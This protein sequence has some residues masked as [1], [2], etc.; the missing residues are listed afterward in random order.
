LARRRKGISQG[1]AA[2][3]LGIKQCTYASYEKDEDRQFRHCPPPDI[4]E[5]ESIDPHEHVVVLRTRLGYTLAEAAE[6]VGTSRATYVQI[7]GGG[8]VAQK[9]ADYAIKQLGSELDDGAET[10]D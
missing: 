8:R 1:Q 10:A 3:E 2:D 5:I 9:W 6:V 7:E 4:P